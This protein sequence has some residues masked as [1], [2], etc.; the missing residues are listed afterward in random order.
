MKPP[1]SRTEL[2]TVTSL[3][4]M[5]GFFMARTPAF[6]VVRVR[7]LLRGDE[8]QSSTK[9]SRSAEIVELGREV[10]NCA[11]RARNAS[12]A[13]ADSGRSTFPALA[14]LV[15]VMDQVDARDDVH[16]L[17]AGHG[18]DAGVARQE[19]AIGLVEMGGDVELRQ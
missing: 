2:K 15:P 18:Q 7:R 19:Q 13:V 14:H 8:G 11:G 1:T 12:G 3:R 16:H 6:E 10:Q 4:R 17:A 9:I 5:R